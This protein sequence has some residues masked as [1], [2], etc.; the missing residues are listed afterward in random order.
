MRL[1]KTM[2]AKASWAYGVLED[3]YGNTWL[4]SPH[5]LF[6][7]W[8]GG[9]GFRSAGKVERGKRE[10]HYCNTFRVLLWNKNV[11][12]QCKVNFFKFN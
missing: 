4:S 7:F 11:R 9:G 6:F 1:C 2:A 5:D 3:F 8:G 10:W 12:F